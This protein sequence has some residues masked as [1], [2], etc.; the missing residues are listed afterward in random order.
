[1]RKAVFLD[2]DGVL[3]EVVYTNGKSR[4]PNNI[5]EV[6][7]MQHA[8][9]NLVRLWYDPSDYL[10]IVVTNQPDVARGNQSRETVDDINEYVYTMLPINSIEVC[11]HDT[12]DNCDCRKPK[13]G[14]FKQAE[15]ELGIR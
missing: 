3:I 14:M 1:M 5:S 10:L 8:I 15:K 12:K 11:Y 6:K 13:V 9:D 2:R 7:I 4:P